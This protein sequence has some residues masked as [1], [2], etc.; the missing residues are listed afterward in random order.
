MTECNDCL[1]WKEC[2]G[3]RH[4]KFPEFRW[5]PHQ[6]LWALEHAEILLSGEWPPDPD[7]SSYTDPNIQTSLAHEG[8][9]VKPELIIGEIERRMKTTREI[10]VS[11]RER[12]EK[13][14]T[15]EQLSSPEYNVLIFVSGD[16]A[17]K[18]TY[19]QWKRGR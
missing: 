6:T 10:G 4:F 11:L 18:Q 12:A 13:G 9:F 1:R 14:Y 2:A 3:K 19:S 15:I 5:C 7:S 8:Y 16:K 17:K